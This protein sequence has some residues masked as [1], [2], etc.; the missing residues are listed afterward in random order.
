MRSGRKIPF[1][2][3]RRAPWPCVR[4][5]RPALAAP[6]ALPPDIRRRRKRSTSNLAWGP[7]THHYAL[8]DTKE[9]TQPLT[10]KPLPFL[11]LSQRWLN[12]DSHSP[13]TSGPHKETQ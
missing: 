5:E 8:T 10:G 4:L 7:P 11:C 1:L 12:N 3:T 9:A 13:I 6:T 2:G